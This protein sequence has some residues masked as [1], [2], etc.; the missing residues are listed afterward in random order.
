VCWCLA[1]SRLANR[2]R[3]LVDADQQVHAVIDRETG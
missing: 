2:A 1:W 3:K